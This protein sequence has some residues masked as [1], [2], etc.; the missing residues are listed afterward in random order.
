MENPIQALRQ[1]KQLSRA[2]LARQ[3]G[4]PYATLTVIEG[5]GF[6]ALGERSAQ[7]LSAYTG[8]NV[9]ALREDYRTWKES[10]LKQAA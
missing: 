5:G 10:K 2:E 7:R 6:N 4:V 9:E 1:E 3:S 8:K